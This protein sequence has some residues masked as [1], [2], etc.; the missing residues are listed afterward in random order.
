MQLPV[1]HDQ[2]QAAFFDENPVAMALV[3]PSHR[4]ARCNDTFC[5]LVGFSRGELLNRTWQSITHP[6]DLDGDQRGAED[7]ARSSDNQLY[8][9]TKRYI[10]KAGQSVWVNLHVRAVWL[11]EKFTGYYVIAI[12]A[13]IAHPSFTATRN[14]GFIEWC[15]TNPKDALLVG[16]A[17]MLF[18]GRDS[19]IE[20]LK[21]WL[22]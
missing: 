22:K 2:W 14:V 11:D 19:A 21:L 8:T 20:L 7:L 9:V 12:P 13:T 4:F 10:H 18:L 15:R 3:A 1:T 17:G 6:D 16:M 5:A